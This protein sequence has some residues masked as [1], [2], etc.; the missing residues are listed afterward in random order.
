MG[1]LV[2]MERSQRRRREGKL[3]SWSRGKGLS[4]QERDALGRSF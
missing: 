4:W 1:P 3:D 2:F